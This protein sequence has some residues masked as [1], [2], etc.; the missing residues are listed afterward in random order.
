MITASGL[1]PAQSSLTLVDCL[2]D[3]GGSG[4]Q[5]GSR[6]MGLQ[7]QGSTAYRVQEVLPPKDP[8]GSGNRSTLEPLGLSKGLLRAEPAR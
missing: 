5:F 6:N 4:E 2:G 3:E 8:K 1:A 7:Q